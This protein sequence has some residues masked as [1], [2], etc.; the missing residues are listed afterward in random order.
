MASSRDVVVPATALEGLEIEKAHLRF[1]LADAEKQNER[2]LG[3]VA[4]YESKVQDLLLLVEINKKVAAEALKCSTA[5]AQKL[6]QAMAKHESQ[7]ELWQRRGEASLLWRRSRRWLSKT[8]DVWKRTLRRVK[9]CRIQRWKLLRRVFSLWKS[10]RS[11]KLATAAHTESPHHA[12][13]IVHSLDALQHKL[14]KQAVA[15]FQPRRTAL[16]R[17]AFAMWKSSLAASQAQSTTAR[18]W[19]RRHLRDNLRKVWTALKTQCHLGATT[20]RSASSRLV[21]SVWTT[22]CRFRAVHFRRRALVFKI[23]DSQRRR[24]LN[25]A[26]VA[27]R[28]E[29]KDRQLCQ[30]LACLESAKTALAE[31]TEACTRLQLEMNSKLEQQTVEEQSRSRAIGNHIDLCLRFFRWGGWIRLERRT[32]RLASLQDMA[33]QRHLA[34]KLFSRW[35]NLHRERLWH[36]RLAVFLRSHHLRWFCHRLLFEW[37]RLVRRSKVV[38]RLVLHA[39]RQTL[40]RHLTKWM[41]VTLQLDKTHAMQL[42]LKYNHV[43]TELD[44]K[45]E[46]SR[47]HGQASH[48]ARYVAHWRQCCYLRACFLQWSRCLSRRR[49]LREL[50][51]VVTTHWQRMIARFFRRWSRETSFHTWTRRLGRV[52]ALHYRHAILQRAWRTWRDRNQRSRRWRRVRFYE[53]SIFHAWRGVVLRHRSRGRAIQ[54]AWSVVYRYCVRRRFVQWRRRLEIENWKTRHDQARQYRRKRRV[55]TAWRSWTWISVHRTAYSVVRC[56]TK[57]QTRHDCHLQHSFFRLWRA[58]T[59]RMEAVRSQAA[60]NLRHGLFGWQWSHV[61]AFYQWKQTWQHQIQRRS[62]LRRALQRPMSKRLRLAWQLWTTKLRMSKLAIDLAAKMR[63]T[64]K[65]CKLDM[66]AFRRRWIVQSSWLSWQLYVKQRWRN[67]EWSHRAFALNQ[68]HVVARLFRHWIEFHRT[69]QLQHAWLVRWQRHEASK[70]LDKAVRRWKQNV[71]LWN[72]QHCQDDVAATNKSMATLLQ[73]QRKA[74]WLRSIVHAWSIWSRRQTLRQKTLQ[75]LVAKAYTQRLRLTWRR[76]LLVSPFRGLQSRGSLLLQQ[77]WSERRLDQSFQAWARNVKRVY[78]CRSL[79]SRLAR[80]KEMAVTR[81]SW[82]RWQRQ[83]WITRASYLRLTLA[84]FASRNGS[85]W[86]QRVRLQRCWY[87]WRRFHRDFQTLRTRW[88]MRQSSMRRAKMQRVL[89]AIALHALGGKQ[90]RRLLA[91]LIR[92]KQLKL[93]RMVWSHWRQ[94]GNNSALRQTHTRVQDRLAQYKHVVARLLVLYETHTLLGRV[95]VA[96]RSQTVPRLERMQAAWTAWT[97]MRTSARTRRQERERRFLNRRFQVWRR[98]VVVR[99]SR[100]RALKALAWRCYVRRLGRGFQT[101]QRVARRLLHHECLD[102]VAVIQGM[103]DAQDRILHAI[104]VS[105]LYFGRW[106]HGLHVEKAVRAAAAAT[107]AAQLR[108]LFHEWTRWTRR[109]RQARLVLQ[110]HWKRRQ[111]AV[112]RAW[113]DGYVLRKL[114]VQSLRRC[115]VL[116]WRRWLRASWTTWRW[117]LRRLERVHQDDARRAVELKHKHQVELLHAKVVKSME[118]LNVVA[119]RVTM[120]KWTA[121]VELQRLQRQHIKLLWRQWRQCA[122]DGALRCLENVWQAWRDQTRRQQ[123]ESATKSLKLVEGHV[124]DVHAK[125]RRRRLLECFAT[126]HQTTIDRRTQTKA[127]AARLESTWTRWRLGLVWK[128]KSKRRHDRFQTLYRWMRRRDLVTS[129]FFTWRL[130]ATASRQR[131]DSPRNQVAVL[132]ACSRRSLRRNVFLLWSRYTQLRSHYR[133]QISTAFVSFVQRRLVVKVWHAWTVKTR[134]QATSRLA[135]V[136]AIRQNAHRRLVGSIWQSWAPRRL[137]SAQWSRFVSA[138]RASQVAQRALAQCLHAWKSWQAQRRRVHRQVERLV[139]VASRFYKYVVGKAYWRWVLATKELAMPRA[140]AWRCDRHDMDDVRAIVAHWGI[141]Q[142][143]A[144][145]A[146]AKRQQRWLTAFFTKQCHTQL[147]R[148]SFAKLKHIKAP[149]CT[150]DENDEKDEEVVRRCFQAWKRWFIDQAIAQAEREHAILVGALQDIAT[151]R[152]TLPSH[153]CH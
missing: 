73:Q 130:A 125:T 116:T 15:L 55:W 95:V 23:L 21:R 41:V 60:R 83:T 38:H 142:W 143:M 133:R 124:D 102:R 111:I 46:C 75:R 121:W 118:R 45:L 144:A 146:Q 91:T 22:W 26:V 122:R 127:A 98:Q 93:T 96:W 12:K 89:I 113:H 82:Q 86:Q 48:M 90:R 64:T 84:E 147:L 104:H 4:A 114:Q 31:E 52:S 61:R 94:Q 132:D 24:L 69:T 120:A 78:V 39:V 151:Y 137:S 36:R 141:V 57:T 29:A 16:R 76:W 101:W 28:L 13:R 25:E 8:F 62:V 139:H 37:W 134:Q 68:R 112:W 65:S 97:T 49:S 20:R 56:Q 129:V 14:E 123:H 138:L 11:T 66:A 32:A 100:V 1:Q 30:W 148:R 72:V 7:V 81:L 149:E 47:R 110:R 17:S 103:V 117:T 63:S 145:T 53:Q 9:H 34:R 150:R 5:T 106:R 131:Y 107:V 67:L 105:R 10:S 71:R 18:L 44:L 51:H 58:W 3:E 40:A 42:Q 119:L 80:R 79:L 136:A 135:V 6:D 59:R 70:A 33:R 92:S 54:E 27:W 43:H 108:V 152:H 126:W 35:T 2:R 153:H 99:H 50:V 140:L 77:R 87:A 85:Q 128:A 109:Q 115:V 19:Y 88:S 74:T